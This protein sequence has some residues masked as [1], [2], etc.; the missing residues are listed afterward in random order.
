MAL[1]LS[2][3]WER[4]G[5]RPPAEKSTYF[6]EDVF[7]DHTRSIRIRFIFRPLPKLLWQGGMASAIALVGMEHAV[8]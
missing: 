5:P 2:S 4:T 7:H 3:S 8:I 1:P 6:F